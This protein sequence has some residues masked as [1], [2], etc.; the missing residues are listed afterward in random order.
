MSLDSVRAAFKAFDGSIHHHHMCG[1]KNVDMDRQEDD[2]AC[3]CGARDLRLALEALDEPPPPPAP[4]RPKQRTTLVGGQHVPL[5][6][7][8]VDLARMSDGAMARTL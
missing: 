8:E 2:S 3:D 7:C 6:F 4:T 5:R 1:P